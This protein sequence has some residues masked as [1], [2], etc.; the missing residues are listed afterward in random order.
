MGPQSRGMGWVGGVIRGDPTPC[1][2]R[3]TFR[4]PGCSQ[5][6]AWPWALPGAGVA[7]MLDSTRKGKCPLPV[8]CQQLFP[9]LFPVLLSQA[10]HPA[11]LGMFRKEPPVNSGVLSDPPRDRRGRGRR[12]RRQQERGEAGIPSCSIPAVSTL[13]PQTTWE[14]CKAGGGHGGEN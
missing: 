5:S 9:G 13:P 7:L 11:L 14:R 12:G 4:C 1:H 10:L 2:G 8:H 3:N 6:P